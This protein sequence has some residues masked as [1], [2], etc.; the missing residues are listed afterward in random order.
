MQK[1]TFNQ[2]EPFC[3]NPATSYCWSLTHLVVNAIVSTTGA[4]YASQLKHESITYQYL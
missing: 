2:N 3:Y 1:H 4:L